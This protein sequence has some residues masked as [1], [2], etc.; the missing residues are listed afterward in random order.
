MQ[1][2]ATM[3]RKIV[4]VPPSLHVTHAWA[5]MQRERIRHLPVLDGGFL[6][7]MV[8][9]RDLLRIGTPQPTG[10]LGFLR[11][12]VEDVMSLEPIVCAPDTS[13]GEAARIMTE[14]KIDALPVVRD[15]LLIGL[16]TSTDL[17]H[18]LV[19]RESVALPFEFRVETVATI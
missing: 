15:G 7:G 1:I 2:R 16:V 10:E 12:H 8:S 17:L 19:E 14:E 18:L 3:T 4:T 5:I 13:V 9:D 11:R 6:V